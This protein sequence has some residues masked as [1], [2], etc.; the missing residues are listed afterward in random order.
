MRICLHSMHTPIQTHTKRN[1]NTF[2]S[3]HGMS[4]QYDRRRRMFRWLVHTQ[5]L[6]DT[7]VDKLCKGAQK[8]ILSLQLKYEELSE[9]NIKKH[10]Y[11]SVLQS[12][13]QTTMHKHKLRDTHTH[14]FICTWKHVY[15]FTRLGVLVNGG[16]RGKGGEGGKAGKSGKGGR[17]RGDIFKKYVRDVGWW[18]NLLRTTFA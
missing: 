3:Y 1:S 2:I 7:D 6:L 12:H 18:T 9:N 13:T 8:S 16:D 17:G 11:V 10:I 15:T 14:T 4:H 5:N